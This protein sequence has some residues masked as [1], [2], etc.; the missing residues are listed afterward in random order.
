MP[1]QTVRERPPDET[2]AN[3]RK[4]RFVPFIAGKIAFA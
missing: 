4:I 3:A 2:A 1:V